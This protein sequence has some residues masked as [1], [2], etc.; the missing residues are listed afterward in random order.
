MEILVSLIEGFVM[1]AGLIIAIG[2]Q[3]AFVLKQG[4][5]GEYRTIIAAICAF[6]DAILIVCGIAGMG[7]LFSSHSLITKIISFSGAA[8]L[9]W[10]SL[11]SFHSAVK[12]DSM[13]I[14]KESFKRLT[15][16]GAVTTTLAL[17]FLN[18]HVY[19][20]TVVM[21]GSFGA[22]RPPEIRPFFGLGAVSAS[23][24]W[25]YALAFSGK[26]LAP[27][28]KKE[29]AWR[30]LD[31]AIGFLMIYIAINLLIFGITL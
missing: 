16:K 27:V 24:V 20:D 31:T 17:T 14:D 25:F 10:F 9:A 13:N 29:R 18:P 22:A 4:I 21:L 23:F 12:G 19:L 3:N 8:Y 5:K 6:S 26:I 30:V 2:A 11:K 28:F 7:V 1:G 15:L